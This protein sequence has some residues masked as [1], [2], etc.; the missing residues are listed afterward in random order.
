LEEPAVQ[1]DTA[2]EVAEAVVALQAVLQGQ[3]DAAAT[4]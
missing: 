1:V 2:A 3:V 4:D